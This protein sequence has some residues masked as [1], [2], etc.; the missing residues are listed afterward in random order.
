MLSKF[1]PA[2]HG[3]AASGDFYNGE[4]LDATSCEVDC[5]EG[6]IFQTY[7]AVNSRRRIQRINCEH[8]LKSRVEFCMYMADLAVAYQGLSS[9]RANA[10]RAG[11]EHLYD[12]CDPS[13]IERYLNNK[14][15]SMAISPHLVDP[16]ASGATGSEAMSSEINR[17]FSNIIQTRASVL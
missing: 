3:D 2:D 1:N 12:A 9:K 14:R 8:G 15:I 13:K 5:R 17:R 7:R 10:S 4:P 11:W 6:L 16:M